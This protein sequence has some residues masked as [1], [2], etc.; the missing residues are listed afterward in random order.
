LTAAQRLLDRLTNRKFARTFN[1]LARRLNP[2]LGRAGKLLV[3]RYYWTL[4]P[5]EYAVR[6]GEYATDI[7]FRDAKSLAEIYPRLVVLLHARRAAVLGPP[8][9]QPLFGRGHLEGERAAR[10]RVRETSGRREFDQN[11][12]QAPKCEFRRRHVKFSIPSTVA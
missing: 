11:V 10:R 1:A 3:N 2:W 8:H 9:E 7:M 5:G 12:R 4:L 6:Q